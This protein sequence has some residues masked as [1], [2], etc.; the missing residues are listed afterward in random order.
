M[1]KDGSTLPCN[2][3][4]WTSS[5]FHLLWH[6]HTHTSS[7]YNTMTCAWIILCVLF[8]NPIVVSQNVDICQMAHRELYVYKHID[9]HR[10]DEKHFIF[11]HTNSGTASYSKMPHLMPR[12]CCQIRLFFNVG[13]SSISPFYVHTIH[14]HNWLEYVEMPS[15]LFAYS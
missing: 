9:T 15:K 4:T 10:S 13:F 11:I 8:D 7:K 1:E 14:F 3:M 12:T 2:I 5:Y 6:K